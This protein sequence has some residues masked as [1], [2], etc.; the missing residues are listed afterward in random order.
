MTDPSRFDVLLVNAPAGSR[1]GCSGL[2]ALKLGVRPG[3]DAWVTKTARYT[4][5]FETM[6]KTNR[7][8]CSAPRK[9]WTLRP[10][11]SKRVRMSDRAEGTADT[12]SR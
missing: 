2:W 4:E 11:P 3:S 1:A 12:Q 7:M 8:L 6:N 10:R 5:H 9:A